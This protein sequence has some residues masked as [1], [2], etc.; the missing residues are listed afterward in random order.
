ML[1][2]EKFYQKVTQ[3]KLTFFHC[4]VCFGW[5]TVVIVV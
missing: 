4:I 2:P 1:E 5:V 3:I